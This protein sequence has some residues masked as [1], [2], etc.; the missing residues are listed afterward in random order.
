[1]DL[2]KLIEV[3]RRIASAVRRAGRE[4]SDV[5]LVVVSK[6][7]SDAEV[8]QLYDG[9]HR[10]FA[11]NRAEALLSRLD[12]PLPVDITW[13][14]VGSV[15]RRKVKLIAPSVELVH[16]M[17]RARLEGVWGQLSDPPPVLLQVNIAAETQ[18]HGYPR[19]EVVEAAQRLVDLGVEVRGLMILPPAPEVAEDSRP[20]F[21]EL[22]SIGAELRLRHP[23]AVELSMGM[24]DDFEVAIECGA[25]MVRLGRAIFGTG[26]PDSGARRVEE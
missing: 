17:D 4:P 13:H 12:G 25:T 15:Q 2:G 11:E 8:Q 22:A 14:F 20:W 6:G 23:D 19:A 26:E 9:G 7:R 1:M 16:S 10:L 18:K 24:S 5:T 21:T 3:R